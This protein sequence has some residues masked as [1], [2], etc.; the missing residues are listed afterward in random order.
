MVMAVTVPTMIALTLFVKFTPLGKAMRATA[1]NPTAAR[2][3][4]INVEWVIAFTFLIGGSLA[5]VA[6]V[7]NGLYNKSVHYQMGFQNGLYAFTAAV[8]GGIGNIPGAVLGGL[9]IG[10]VGELAKAYLG[11]K[12]SEAVV[13]TILIVI[14]L[15]RPAGLLGTRTREKV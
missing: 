15:F 1:Q 6:A 11:T 12:W 14:L 3:M 2:L 8:L 5:G 13:F 7:I 9:V 10:V 4:G